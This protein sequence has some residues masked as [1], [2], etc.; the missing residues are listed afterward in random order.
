MFRRHKSNLTSSLHKLRKPLTELQQQASED[1]VWQALSRTIAQSSTMETI[2]SQ[3]GGAPVE[4]PRS[5]NRWFIQVGALATGLAVVVAFTAYQLRPTSTPDTSSTTEGPTAAE[6]AFYQET[7]NKS[8]SAGN[9][10]AGASLGLAA[11]KKAISISKSG[12]VYADGS[13]YIY[14]PTVFFSDTEGDWEA[15]TSRT[16]VYALNTR[17]QQVESIKEAARTE[18][19]LFSSINQKLAYI[20]YPTEFQDTPFGENSLHVMDFKT[21]KDEVVVTLEGSSFT[22]MSWSPDGRYLLV[23]R[24]RDEG[25]RPLDVESAVSETYNIHLGVVDMQSGTFRNFPNPEPRML[26]GF[27]G[28]WSSNSEV[29]VRFT[30]QVENLPEV[31]YSL[32]ADS[33]EYTETQGV[34]S[35]INSLIEDGVE[36]S[37]VVPDIYNQG[38]VWSDSIAYAPVGQPTAL[39]AVPNTKSAYQFLLQKGKDNTVTNLLF[40]RESSYVAQDSNEVLPPAG[41]FLANLSTGAQV[42]YDLPTPIGGYLQLAGW[43]GSYNKVVYMANTSEADGYRLQVRSLNLDTKEDLALYTRPAR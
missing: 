32:N 31:M 24:N 3:T 35:A 34:V 9:S 15:G 6:L 38:K 13:M 1:R 37:Y 17:T 42:K 27:T 12:T 41:I 5:K 14:D 29:R 7:A 33:G 25:G 8:W 39:T 16:V 11:Y 43:L 26:P 21:R 23:E 20:S 40:A 10:K 22:P 28:A 2:S 18:R 30:K 19:P 36:Y 4:L